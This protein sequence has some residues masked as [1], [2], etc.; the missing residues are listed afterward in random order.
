MGAAHALERIADPGRDQ[1]SAWS[2]W[3]APRIGNKPIAAITRDDVEN[4]RDAL[5]RAVAER[6]KQRGRAGLSVADKT[7]ANLRR[8]RD[9]KATNCGAKGRQGSR[10]ALMGRRVNRLAQLKRG[11]TSGHGRMTD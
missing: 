7:P 4:V 5:D 3:I 9:S 11:R 2:A 10:R 6:K 1:E 8:G